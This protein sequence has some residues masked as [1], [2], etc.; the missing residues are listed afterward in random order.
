MTLPCTTRIAG[1][2]TVRDWVELKARL[3]RNPPS[4][5]WEEAMNCFFLKRL[6]TRYFSPI[7]T[8]E[9]AKAV[10]GEGFAIVALHCSLIEFLASTREGKT[11]RHRKNGEPALN[12]ALEYSDSHAMFVKFLENCE[13]FKGMFSIDG[14]AGDFYSN[15]RCGLFHEA[16]TKGRWL[17]RVDSKAIQAIDTTCKVIYRNMMQAAFDQFVCLYAKQIATDPEL[18]Q[19]FMR[20]FDSLCC[21]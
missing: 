21:E 14:S 19:A 17:I 10:D 18:Q 6:E 8:L 5:V 4:A 2:K 20:K 1:N 9:K 16:R 11:Y 3:T 7:R 15:V 12:P 13:P